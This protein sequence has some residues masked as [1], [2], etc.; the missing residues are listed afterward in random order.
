MTF[1]AAAV[2]IVGE[3]VKSPY[4]TRIVPVNTPEN[5]VKFRF[6]IGMFVVTAAP[7]VSVPAV[8]FTSGAS[9]SV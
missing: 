1:A 3:R 7:T 6:R 4:T 2:V 9:A 5:P 8:T